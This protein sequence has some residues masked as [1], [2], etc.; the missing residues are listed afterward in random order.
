MC[1][2]TWAALWGSGPGTAWL[3]RK[4]TVKYVLIHT[5][6]VPGPSEFE[7]T[8]GVGDAAPPAGGLIN[9][10][11][12]P[13]FSVCTPPLSPGSW[14][15]S[16]LS[17]ASE[18]QVSGATQQTH[19]RLVPR[20]RVWHSPLHGDPRSAVH[21][22]ALGLFPVCSVTRCVIRPGCVCLCV[23]ARGCGRTCVCL[24][25]GFCCT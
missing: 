8:Q 20:S 2:H 13:G 17:G 25:T 6:T 18:L 22:L 3:G 5:L 11:D 15:C 21:S 10:P 16:Q 23:C 24:N 9:C 1:A 14:S 12:P 4:C 7:H 19:L